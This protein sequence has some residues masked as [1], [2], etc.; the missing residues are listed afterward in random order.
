MARPRLKGTNY[1]MSIHVANGHRYASTQPLV[2]DGETGMTRNVRIHWGTVDDNLRFLPG[3]RFFY[4]SPAV[5]A[6]FVYPDNWDLGELDKLSGT[7]GAGRP[8]YDEEDANR[9]YGDVWLLE[10]V[11][12]KTGLKADLYFDAV[13]RGTEMTALDVSIAMQRKALHHLRL[14]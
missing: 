10:Q 2:V 1:K 3:K 13:R 4:T 12:E 8:A 7:R 14:T 5:R 6:K 11:A 9:F